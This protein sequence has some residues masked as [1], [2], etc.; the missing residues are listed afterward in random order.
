MVVH[1]DCNN[2]FVSCEL[3]SRPELV[4]TPV[5]VANDNNNHGGIILA[6]NQEAK[7]VGLKR[8]NP[9]FQ[10]THIIRDQHVTVINVHHNLYH[11]I[12]AQIMDVVRRSDLVLDF[13]QY[14][15]DEFF[16]SMPD[17][18]PTRLRTY[19]YQLKELIYS[20]THI[21]VSCGAGLTYTLAKTATYYAKHYTGYQGICVMPDDKR[22]PALQGLAVR[23]IWGIGRR[24]S[25]PLAQMGV[26]TA[27]DFAQLNE[28]AVQRLFGIRGV[29]IWREL[30]GT[31]AVLL[32][33]HSARQQSIMYSRTFT[34]MVATR[35]E[36]QTF[37]SDFTAAACRRLRAQHSLC[38]GVT[39]FLA[40][41]RHRED[42]PQ[43][44]NDQSMRL[45]TATDDTIRISETVM[46]LLDRIYR[47]GYL[48]KQAGVVLTG[49]QESDGVQLDLFSSDYV[50]EAQKRK[51]LMQAFDRIN[52]K[53]GSN[54]IHFCSQGDTDAEQMEGFMRPKK[55]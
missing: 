41:N 35:Q 52:T 32:T 36:L 20:K 16:G 33:A 28:Q 12:S 7:A 50:E 42:L 18:N 27:W 30:N 29:R 43:Y 6:L 4:G 39:L 21:L 31:P 9:L 14:S 47:S 55:I 15:V 38:T 26:Q 1:I 54:K 45:S 51:K 2:F 19:L 3:I 10:V 44:S 34:S 37:L 11:Q 40:T 8:G 53:H 48:Y 5:V 25:K 13:V 49:L 23:D 22:Q 24:S 46:L 17:D